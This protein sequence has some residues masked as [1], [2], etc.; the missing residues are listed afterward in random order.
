MIFIGLSAGDTV[1]NKTGL[2]KWAL[3]ALS[4]LRERLIIVLSTITH[5]QK[6]KKPK[7]IINYVYKLR[8]K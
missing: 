8:R 6:N 1:V 3:R 4:F 2:P 5:T 7:T